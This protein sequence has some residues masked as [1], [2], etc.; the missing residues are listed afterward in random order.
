MTEIN[1]NDDKAIIDSTASLAIAR[2]QTAIDLCKKLKQL[3]L[4]DRAQVAE[5]QI[6]IDDIA[7]QVKFGNERIRQVYASADIAAANLSD[8]IKPEAFH[9]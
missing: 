6:A 5:T 3:D 8:N 1:M 4:N 7:D 9:L 2:L